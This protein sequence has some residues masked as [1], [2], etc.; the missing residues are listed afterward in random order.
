MTKYILITGANSGIGYFMSSSLLKKGHYVAML[1]LRIDAL[2]KLKFEYRDRVL[3]YECDIT[4][5]AAVQESI[6]SIYK[7]WPKLDIVVNN[8]CKVL[9]GSF[10]EITE[11]EIRQIFDVNVFGTLNVTHAVLPHMLR[12][13]EGIIHNISSGVGITGF[14]NL[15]GYASSK[16]AVETLTKCLALEYS[17]TN[18]IFNLIHPPLTNTPSAKPIGL[19]SGMLEDAEKVG[20]LLAKK[21]GSKRKVITADWKSNAGIQMMK[22][23]P[24]FMG[25]MMTKLTFKN[26]LNQ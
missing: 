25:R 2:Q 5:R 4:D 18:V 26:K 16:G 13:N 15:L 19:P 7:L 11:E 6:S 8:A 23:F 1:D 21:I 17:H 22:V 9:F 3:N 12:R 10:E 24:Y 14:K 20:R